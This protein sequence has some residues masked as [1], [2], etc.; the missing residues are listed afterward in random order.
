MIVKEYKSARDFL[1][2][3]ETILLE[4]ES[5]SQLVLYGAYH[6]IK[7]EIDKSAV[8]GAVI[9]DEKVYLLFCNVTPYEL[10]I[11]SIQPD[12]VITAAGVLAEFLSS[13]HIAIK[14]MIAAYD[15]CLSFMEEYKKYINC[16]F[17]EKMGMDIMEI[18][19]INEINPVDGMHR[20]ALPVEAKL[21]AQWMI[22][23]QM[24]ARTSEMDY[25][26]ALQRATKQIEEGKIHFYEDAQHNVVTMAVAA[27]KL[28]HGV[29][30]T[31]I[32]TPEENRGKGYAAANIYYLSK[33]LL[34][35]GNEFCTIFVDKKNPLST[36]AYEKVG[37]K[38][39]GDS[40][41]YTVVPNKV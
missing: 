9:D 25:E 26:A 7:I 41:E 35:Q 28:A 14:G 21:V 33:K 40:Y 30:I 3:Y 22:E 12:N 32:Y 4:H 11:Y 20:L 34:E 17:E 39:I 38:V 13:N 10:L 8:F 24:E 6:N 31:Y 29:T 16:S 19:E 15:L 37:Y 1:D 23:F 5:K 18:R 2:D 27:R 36:R